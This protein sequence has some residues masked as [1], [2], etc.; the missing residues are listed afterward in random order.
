MALHSLVNSLFCRARL[1]AS[2]GCSGGIPSLDCTLPTCPA[3][4]RAEGFFL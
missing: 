2:K 4:K 1:L 3:G